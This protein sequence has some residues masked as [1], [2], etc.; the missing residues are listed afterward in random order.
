M[1]LS[2]PQP[3]PAADFFSG[4]EGFESVGKDLGGHANARI[5]DIQAHKIPGE[6][7]IG[8]RRHV[9]RPNFNGSAA[10]DGIARIQ[11][12]IENDQLEFARINLYAPQTISKAGL[13]LYIA[14]Q[15][16]I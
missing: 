1:R 15:A 8:Q 11:G 14:A 7:V 3:G 13:N 5:C 16:S 10:R 12:Q 2:E 6:V 4:K 9:S